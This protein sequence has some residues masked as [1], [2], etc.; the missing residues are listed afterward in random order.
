VA[1]GQR[2]SAAGGGWRMIARPPGFGVDGCFIS[3]PDLCSSCGIAPLWVWRQRE[4]S[5]G[6]R[7]VWGYEPAGPLGS[8]RSVRALW[9][10]A[11]PLVRRVSS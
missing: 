5:G 9:C 10:R 2:A 8:R 1:S 6:I 11:Q 7:V 3:R 4:G